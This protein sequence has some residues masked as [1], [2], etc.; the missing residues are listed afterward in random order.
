MFL[1]VTARNDWS[2]ALAFTDGVSFFYPS[3]GAS[4]LLDKFVDFG[5]NVDMFKLRA[6][7]SI[8]GNDVPVFMTNLRYTLKDQ[9]SITPPEKAPFKTLKPEKQILWKLV[10]TVHSSVIV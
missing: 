1:D 8:V 3:V 10:S 9:G 6:S 5:K 4:A 7:Y 2:S